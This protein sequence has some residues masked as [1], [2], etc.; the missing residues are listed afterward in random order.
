MTPTAPTVPELLSWAPVP[1]V[2][3]T[4]FMGDHWAELMSNRALFGR[5][6]PDRDR[7]WRA[8]WAEIGP[9]GPPTAV[10]A[11]VAST[12]PDDALDT[13]LGAAWDDVGAAAALM[14]SLARRGLD[15]DDPRWD[16]ACDLV[17]TRA[18]PGDAIAA[19]EAL[20]ASP[21]VPF[22]CRDRLVVDTRFAAR[23]A[24]V[25]HGPW[26]TLSAPERARVAGATTST[27]G[28]GRPSTLDDFTA[29]RALSYAD[30]AAAAQLAE[31]A[32]AATLTTEVRCGYLAALRVHEIA[33]ARAHQLVAELHAL[34]AVAPA[35]SEPARVVVASLAAP[36]GAP[37]EI[38]DAA[39]R[40]M[41]AQTDHIELYNGA[42]AWRSAVDTIRSPAAAAASLPWPPDTVGAEL[43]FAEVPTG[44]DVSAVGSSAPAW[45]LLL[46]LADGA[47][48]LTDLVAMAAAVAD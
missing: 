7:L 33:P 37:W 10:A 38:R 45:R 31:V 30:T 6:G 39:D 42:K 24:A 25:L 20:A 13:M 28:A 5:A 4:E 29:I 47:T 16:T 35:M 9:A 41:S 2:V 11:L 8:A 32:G 26:S 15:H 40:W 43:A 21:N 18:H 14:T 17:C 34:V 12:A 3:A 44:V 27:W 48:P 46:E 19:V 36:S 23:A 22:R 1:E